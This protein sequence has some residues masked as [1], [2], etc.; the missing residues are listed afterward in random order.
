MIREIDGDY[1]SKVTEIAQ[2]IPAE[3]DRL[4]RRKSR[5]V[6]RGF[7]TSLIRN[8]FTDRNYKELPTTGTWPYRIEGQ[9]AAFLRREWVDH[10]D[11]TKG[12]NNM[13]VLPTVGITLRTRGSRRFTEID[14]R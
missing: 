14:L 2:S 1:I 5:A 12:I 6:C 8:I 7:V 9:T 4:V 13:A 11:H 3:P 10:T